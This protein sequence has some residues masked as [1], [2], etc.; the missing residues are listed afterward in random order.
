MKTKKHRDN[1]LNYFGERGNLIAV[2]EPVIPKKKALKREHGL[3]DFIGT[4]IKIKD[5]F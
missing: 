4:D 5:M 1:A 3:A 2:N